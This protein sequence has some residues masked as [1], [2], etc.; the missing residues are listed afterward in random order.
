MKKQNNATPFL[1]MKAAFKL[2]VF[3]LFLPLSVLCQEKISK[4]AVGPNGDQYRFV[5]AFVE[6][7]E[8]SFKMQSMIIDITP[9]KSNQDTPKTVFLDLTA[10]VRD[11]GKGT[12]M[13]KILQMRWNKN[14]KLK[15]KCDGKWAE[16]PTEIETTA[17]IETVKS[18]IRSLPIKT[19]P[20]SEVT[21]S[22]E[23]EK[24]IIAV[25]D[26]MNG[27]TLPCL[28]NNQ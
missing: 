14:D 24:K 1:F 28:R 18:V 10:T 27:S 12:K 6:T 3:V 25:V 11:L 22:P 21:L 20:A 2:L 19:E 13:Q 5:I 8:T 7:D 17:I 4:T 16:K 9:I 26:S 23:I 15:I